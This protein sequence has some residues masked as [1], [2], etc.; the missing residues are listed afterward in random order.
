MLLVT[1]VIKYILDTVGIQEVMLP[2]SDRDK[3][4]LYFT[5]E[6]VTRTTA[7]GLAFY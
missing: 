6:N 7:S 4:R 3:K 1:K 2:V 5:V